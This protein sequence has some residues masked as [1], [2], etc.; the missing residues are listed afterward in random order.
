MEIA[1]TSTSSSLLPYLKPRL[2]GIFFQFVLPEKGDATQ[3]AS[4]SEPSGPFTRLRRAHLTIGGCH[5]LMDVI[6]VHQPDI[7]SIEP[8]ELKPLTNLDVEHIWQQTWARLSKLDEKKRPFVLPCQINESGGLVPLKPLFYCSHK[9]WFCHPMCPLCGSSL[10]LCRDDHLLMTAGLPTYSG[11]LNRYLYCKSCHDNEEGALFYTRTLTNEPSAAVK[12]CDALVEAFSRLLAK[13]NLSGRLPCIG[14][15]EAVNCYGPQNLVLKRMQP[16]QFFPFHMLMQHAP[17]LNAVEFVALLSGAGPKD[18]AQLSICRTGVYEQNRFERISPMFSQTAGFLFTQDDRLFLEVLYLKLTF[19]QELLALVQQRAFFPVSRMSLEGIG[20]EIHEPGSKLPSFWHF[21]LKLTDPIG[22]PNPQ[23]PDSQLPNLLAN[24]FLGLA[25]FY[26]LLVNEEQTMVQVN[27]ALQEVM[28]RAM[29]EKHVITELMSLPAFEPGNIFW[30]PQ[31]L[32]LKSQWHALWVD[33]LEQGNALVQAGKG[34]HSDFSE[35]AFE[36]AL[37]NLRASVH[38]ELFKLPSSVRPSSSKPGVDA[39]ARI[40]AILSNIFAKWAQTSE[41]PLP[42]NATMDQPPGADIAAQDR[43]NENDDLVET[44][45]LSDDA[46]PSVKPGLRERLFGIVADVEETVLISPSPVGRPEKEALDDLEETV[47]IDSGQK[48]PSLQPPDEALDQ[49]VMI[50]PMSKQTDEG[51]PDKTVIQ[52]PASLPSVD[53]NMGETVLQKPAQTTTEP[54]DLEKT[55]L[56]SSQGQTT[57]PSGS[58]S[59]ADTPP[60]VKPEKSDEDELEKTVFIQPPN[61]QRRKPKT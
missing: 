9:D 29:D 32:R 2:D 52:S 11:S 16:L 28:A 40:E 45:I 60:A 61:D 15:D 8:S 41:T 1:D 20:V 3:G 56:I 58:V 4:D 30:R 31:T 34:N 19:L 42:D 37:A 35:S 21:S 12:D 54:E 36:H 47:V 50:A 43:V 55:V 25:W 10:D 23:S 53:D 22:H 46:L 26:V 51:D 18:M 44:V 7:Y 14:C 27:G 33:A 48:P 59:A 38:Q 39:D 13:S 24:E 5:K 57:S 49:T 6:C 17:T